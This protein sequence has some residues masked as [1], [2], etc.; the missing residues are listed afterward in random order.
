[1]AFCANCGTEMSDEAPACPKCGHPRTSAARRT[2]GTAIVALVLGILGIVSCPL[3]LS[4]PAVIVGNQARAR[5]RENPSLE[6]D[7]LA[8][9]GVIMGWVGIGFFGIG[10]VIGILALVFGAALPAI[11]GPF[12]NALSTLG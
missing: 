2:E 3:I 11:D 5:I 12:R 1:M 6:G 8:R 4:I 9:A 10:L 7:G